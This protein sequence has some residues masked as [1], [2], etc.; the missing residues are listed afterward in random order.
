MYCR[1]KPSL[2][3]LSYSLTP[4]VFFF[5]H[6][7]RHAPS[8]RRPV[9]SPLMRCSLFGCAHKKIT[10]CMYTNMIA[11]VFQGIQFSMMAKRNLPHRTVTGERLSVTQGWQTVWSKQEKFTMHPIN[12]TCRPSKNDLRLKPHSNI[13]QELILFIVVFH[14]E[15]L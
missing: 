3:L 8:Y 7:Q 14:S 10:L 13:L 11:F 12:R 15:M 1:T 6:L 5:W 9:R 4:V 2:P